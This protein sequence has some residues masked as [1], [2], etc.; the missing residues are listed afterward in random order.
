MGVNQDGVT[1]IIYFF[2]CLKESLSF[3]FFFGRKSNRTLGP[4][5]SPMSHVS[6]RI[7][8]VHVCACI[9]L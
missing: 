8:F 9:S 4:R 6:H 2:F 5:F 7:S 1:F 3:F